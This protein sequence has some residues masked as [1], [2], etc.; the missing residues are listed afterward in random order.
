MRETEPLFAGLIDEAT[1]LPDKLR[2][3][4]GEGAELSRQPQK[5][6]AAPLEIVV[7]VEPWFTV[8]Y[9][10]GLAL[11]RDAEFSRAADLVLRGRGCFE[12]L[13]T[14]TPGLVVFPR[15]LIGADGQLLWT[16]VR[17]STS[18]SP[19]TSGRIRVLPTIRCVA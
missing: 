13:R 7:T 11:V 14:Q 10:A 19:E 1:M 9:L 6:V 5:G 2:R 3:L 8:Q 15:V 12:L 4:A 17:S 16:W 18:S